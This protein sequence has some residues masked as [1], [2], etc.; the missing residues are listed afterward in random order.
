MKKLLLSLSTILFSAFTFGQLNAVLNAPPNITGTGLR[1]PS[2][3]LARTFLRVSSIVQ[4]SELSSIPA[5]TTIDSFGFVSNTGASVQVA[6]NITVYM[7][8]ST[9]ANF[10]LGTDWATIIAGM[11][12]VYSGAYTVPNTATNIDLTLSTPFVYT[13]GSVYVAFDFNRTGTA[14][15]AGAVYGA[16][17][18]LVGGCVSQVNQTAAPTTLVANDFRPSIRFGYVNPNSND[19]SIEAISSLGNVATALG[20]PTPISAIV[21][22]KSNTTLT[23]V[24]VSAGVSGSNSYSNTQTISTL[25]AGAA[26]TVNFADWTP[27]ALGTNVINVSVPA[28]QVNSNNSINF[29]STTTCFTSGKGQSGVSYAAGVGFNTG[30]GIISTPILNSVATTIVGVNLAISS[31]AA[32]VGKTV[33]GVLLDNSGAILAQSP[34]TVLAASDSSTIKSFTFPTAISVAAGQQV[35]I[36]LGQVVNAVGFFP[37]GSYSNP[38]LTTTYN[39]CAITGG[40]L[41]LLAA[42]LG[43]LGLE[44]VFSGT[45]TLG[46][47]DVDVINNKIVTYPNPVLNIVTIANTDN[48][49]IKS[50]SIADLNGRVIKTKN[51]DNVS[52]IKMNISDL[53]SGVYLM[54]I[55]ASEGSIV[56]KI[57]KN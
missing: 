16:N 4:A 54:N 21:T 24:V 6:G 30:T 44:V 41:T 3:T 51:V 1:G 33:F 25:A 10:T 31:D 28:D 38:N 5:N 36:G 42:N 56:K 15:T 34:N 26:T 39:T 29:N 53:S 27:T 9:D 13:G 19:M 48:L 37:I 50:I 2:G 40:V 43:Q 57:I 8:N 7:L 35:H 49:N 55:N 45:C 14:A 22:N 47:E 12:Q 18:T 20:L 52:E 17:N 11:T 32:S 23:N 46:N